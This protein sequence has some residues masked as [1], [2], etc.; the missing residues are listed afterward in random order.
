MNV[1]EMTPQQWSH[2]Y[3]TVPGRLQRANTCLGIARKVAG[4]IR[5]NSQ[6]MLF[7]FD[8]HRRIR[9]EANRIKRNYAQQAIGE[10]LIALVLLRTGTG[11]LA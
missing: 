4:N 11:N 8:D 10:M 5:D 2:F 1:S 7:L 3:R 9:R 6:S